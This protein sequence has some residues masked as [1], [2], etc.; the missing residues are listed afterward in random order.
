M[1]ENDPEPTEPEIEKE[2]E[3]QEIE[4]EIEKEIEAEKPAPKREVVQRRKLLPNRQNPKR[5]A[6]RL[7]HMN[8]LECQ[9]PNRKLQACS[10]QQSTTQL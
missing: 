10:R 6:D 3:I 7:C 5:E 4:K 9:S 2:P 8:S 1:P